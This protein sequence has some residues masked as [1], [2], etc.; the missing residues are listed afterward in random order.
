MTP[1]SV[2]SQV[3]RDGARN[4]V[5]RLSARGD[6]TGVQLTNVKVVNVAAMS[7]PA[8]SGFKIRR[9]DSTVF[10][11]TV[12]LAWESLDPVNPVPF[13]ELQF[14]GEEHEFERFGGLS[15]Q[16]VPNATGNVLLST[17]GFDAQS[18]FTIVLEA[19]KGNTL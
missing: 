1:A 9:L 3:L 12:E 18:G 19:I 10:G 17:Y 7:P 6:G 13:A 2:S 14:A 15:T 4:F 16:N 5:L 8:G 11:G